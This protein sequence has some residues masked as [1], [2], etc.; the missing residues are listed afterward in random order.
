M[1]NLG[2]LQTTKTWNESLADLAEE[3]RKWGVE[4][5][6]MPTKAVSERDR[7]VTVAFALNG[8]WVNPECQRWQKIDANNWLERNLR[9]IVMAVT[10]AR[11]MDQRGLGALLAETTRP[12]ALNAGDDPYVILGFSRDQ[13]ANANRAAFRRIVQRHHPDVGGDPDRFK[14]ILDAGEKL[15]FR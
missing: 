13:P 8:T 1:P 12:L 9:A 5:Y 10:S 3:F 11:L 6:I 4:D 14:A 2:S 7:K 15:G